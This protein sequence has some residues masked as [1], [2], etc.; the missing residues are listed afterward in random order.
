ME[1]NRTGVR[2]GIFALLA[3]RFENQTLTSFTK[4][5]VFQQIFATLKLKTPLLQCFRY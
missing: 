1:S 5:A 4:L 2:K 3:F